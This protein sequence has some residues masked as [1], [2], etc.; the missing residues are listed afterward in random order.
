MGSRL[1]GRLLN[2]GFKLSLYDNAPKCLSNISINNAQTFTSLTNLINSIAAP[3][4]IFLCIP[5]GETVDKVI[6]E[7]LPVLTQNDTL[8]D[9]GNSYSQDS[10]RRAE[11]LK[12]QQLNYLELGS[13]ERI[14]ALKG[15]PLQRELHK[16][17]LA[18][19]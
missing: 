14:D 12:K 6:Q 19:D 5:A 3:R 13:A 18:D 16:S 11:T 15:K 8:I 1:A 9:L 17:E 10:Q 2:A 4:T 7:M